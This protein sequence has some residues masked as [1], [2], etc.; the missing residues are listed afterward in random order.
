MTLNFNSVK[1]GADEQGGGHMKLSRLRG[2]IVEEYGT[3]RNF[4]QSMGISESTVSLKLTGKVGF[5]T[6][7]I[8]K[9]SEALDI[10]KEEYGKYYFA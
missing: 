6:K 1:V 3:N 2:K 9:W 10:K 8:E 5:S 4:S 7:E